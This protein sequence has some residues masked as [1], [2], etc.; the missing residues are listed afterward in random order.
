MYL[1]HI[2]LSTGETSVTFFFKN[3]SDLHHTL[4]NQQKSI[5]MHTKTPLHLSKHT[6]KSFTPCI[7]HTL[8][9]LIIRVLL[10]NFPHF[11]EYAHKSALA[12]PQTSTQLPLLSYAIFTQL[13]LH[14]YSHTTNAIFLPRKSQ[15]LSPFPPPQP[16]TLS[17]S[18]PA[19]NT[20][21]CCSVS[22]VHKLLPFLLHYQ[23]LT[24]QPTPQS[25]NQASR[26]TVSYA[27][28]PQ[29]E[30]LHLPF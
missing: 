24:S 4:H 8:F 22:D 15:L 3:S 25:A 27:R 16:T 17:I 21:Q 7:S 1:T 19:N 10:L 26:H 18:L 5:N 14:H 20:L 30:R 23:Y 28:I 29:D 2:H 9:Q 6:T 12:R 13:L 11:A